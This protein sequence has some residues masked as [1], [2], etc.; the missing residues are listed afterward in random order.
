[1]RQVQQIVNKV[2]HVRDRLEN[3]AE[4]APRPL[5]K[6]LG[7]LLLQDARVAV[8]VPQRRAQVVRDRLAERFEFLVERAEF[9]E[10]EVQL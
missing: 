4:I 2:S 5:R 7:A 10:L 6:L 1:M 8:D 3:L 9:D